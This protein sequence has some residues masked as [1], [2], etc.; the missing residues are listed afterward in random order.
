METHKVGV[1]GIHCL[2]VANLAMNLTD[3]PAGTI[4][5]LCGALVII[6][7]RIAPGEDMTGLIGIVTQMLS[8]FS[9]SE[10]SE[11]VVGHA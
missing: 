2:A 9:K 10:S 6:Q 1:Q 3:T 7:E 4:A 11:E 8:S 5:L